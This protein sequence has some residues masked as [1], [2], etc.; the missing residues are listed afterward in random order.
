MSG[1]IEGKGL[2]DPK[3]LPKKSKKSGVEL[4]PELKTNVQRDAAALTRT[5]AQRPLVPA[6]TPWRAGQ[7]VDVLEALKNP[8][9]VGQLGRV[10][11]AKFGEVLVRIP[12][13]GREYVLHA[14]EKRQL[15]QRSK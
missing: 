4:D 12:A 11:E 6:G 9:L 14:F 5:M 7:P 8:E 2:G 13:D 10:V 15:R 3:R 1:A